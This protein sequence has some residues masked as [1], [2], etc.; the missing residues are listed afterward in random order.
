MEYGMAFTL[1][2][3]MVLAFHLGGRVARYF[4]ARRA[5]RPVAPSRGPASDWYCYSKP[6]TLWGRQPKPTPRR[7]ASSDRPRTTM[8]PAVRA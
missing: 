2:V 3:G 4:R 8:R 6:S 7:P 1:F 5:G